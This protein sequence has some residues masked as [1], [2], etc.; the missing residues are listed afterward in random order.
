[1][2]RPS[3]LDKSYRPGRLS[4]FPHQ[5]DNRATLFQAI[6]NAETTLK[7]SLTVSSKSIILD[8][9]SLFPPNGIIKITHAKDLGEPEAIYYGAKIGNQL[10]QVH[11]GF[12]GFRMSAWP[13]GSIVTLPVMADHHNALKDAIIRIEEQIGLKDNPAVGSIS[14]TLVA[15]EKKW[16]IPKPIF[17]A[18]PT[19]GTAPLTVRFQNLSN[20]HGFRFL[21][22]FGDGTSSTERSP[23]HTFEEEGKYNVQLTMVSHNGAS[24]IVQKPD[25]IA[26]IK[27]DLRTFFYVNAQTGVSEETAQDKAT[28]FELVDQTDAEV[29]ERHWFFGDGKDITINNPNEHSVTHTFAKPGQYRPILLLRLA[30]NKLIKAS[31]DMLMVE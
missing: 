10:H 9:A 15:L 4:A 14:A 20:T 18:Y 2:K 29:I 11:R 8:D 7:Q 12:G 28:V 6:N 22:T 16:L 26:V 31:T 5:A 27:S 17:K 23:L 13:V 21:W 25:Y 3:S 19:T 24:G 1:M 30:N